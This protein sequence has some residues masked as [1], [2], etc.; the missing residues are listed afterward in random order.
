MA[1]VFSLLPRARLILSRDNTGST[2]AVTIGMIENFAR[3]LTLPRTVQ[4]RSQ[5]SR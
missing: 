4:P 1:E 3:K 2:V 5:S